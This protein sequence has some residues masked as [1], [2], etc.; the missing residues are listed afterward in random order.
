MI[1][2]KEFKPVSLLQERS[3]L[4]VPWSALGIT[5]EKAQCIAPLRTTELFIRQVL[6]EA[7]SRSHIRKWFTSQNW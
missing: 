7:D 1:D 2:L 5:T 6:R 3:K 4:L